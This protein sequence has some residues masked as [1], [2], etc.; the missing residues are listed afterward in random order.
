MKLRAKLILALTAVFV[1]FFA[2]INL[3]GISF[4]GGICILT[5]LK[6]TDFP[7]FMEPTY[8]KTVKQS[9]PNKSLRD[10]VVRENSVEEIVSKDWR[11][12]GW[13]GNGIYNQN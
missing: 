6:K 7:A 2:I 13:I 4:L 3:E 8:E 10:S 5:Y 1:V 11:I 9:D 12:D